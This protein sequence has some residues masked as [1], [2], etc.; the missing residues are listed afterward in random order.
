MQIDCKSTHGKSLKLG[1]QTNIGNI[2][3][4]SKKMALD[5]APKKAKS[6]TIRR[7]INTLYD[8]RFSPKETG[9]ATILV[10]YYT[11]TLEGEICIAAM[12]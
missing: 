5:W 11:G 9:Y 6:F 1:V 8:G 7:I 2:E 3:I 12:L 10:N 4:A